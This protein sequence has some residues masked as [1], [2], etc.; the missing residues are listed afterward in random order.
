MVRNKVVADTLAA[1][2]ARKKVV[3]SDRLVAF[4]VDCK[5]VVPVEIDVDC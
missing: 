1:F 3:H 4:V 2:V 5:E